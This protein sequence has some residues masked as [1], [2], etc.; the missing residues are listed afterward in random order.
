VLNA[1]TVRNLLTST[2]EDLGTAGRDKRYGFGMVNVAA[3]VAAAGPRSPAVYVALTLDNTLYD[4]SVT[5]A[6]LT[7]S[8]T[9][10]AGTAISGLA[11]S[12]FATAFDDS[13]ATVNF[14]ETGTP[15]TYAA[16]LDINAA[17][18]G[19]H[20]VTVQ[21]TSGVLTGDDTAAFLIGS[22][23]EPGTVHVPSI[24]YA[25]G[26]GRGGKRNLYITVTTVD[27]NSA[28]VGNAIVDVFVYVNGALWSYGQG[29]TDSAGHLT[30]NSTNAPEGT[31][32]TEIIGV[33]AG[34]LVWDGITPPNSF[35]R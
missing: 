20:S 26:S 7:V 13:P 2:A 15:G 33:S 11:S 32:Y 19:Q 29:A 3:A 4:E 21:A 31:Y 1:A 22:T 16:P 18:V 25:S 12:A 28:P 8:V 5:D 24:T 34:A 23:P 6:T 10:Q 35:V 30:F 9:D 27:G 17:P 14:L